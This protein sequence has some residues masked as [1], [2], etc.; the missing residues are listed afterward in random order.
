MNTKRIVLPIVVAALAATVMS[1][2]RHPTLRYSPEE[3][4]RLRNVQIFL[5]EPTRNY[6][7]IATVSGMGGRH[8]AKETMMNAMI[9]E[10][11]SSGA[12]ALIPLAFPASKPLHFVDAFLHTE[13]G[14]TITK[15]NAIK[16]EADPRWQQP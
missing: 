15:G 4:A 11:K 14:K 7:V 12:D 16:W 6:R 10:A 1:C 13:D 8:T 5:S 9:D 3:Y 2:Q